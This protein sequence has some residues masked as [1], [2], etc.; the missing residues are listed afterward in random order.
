VIRTWWPRS[1]SARSPRAR[2]YRACALGAAPAL[3]V[4][5]WFALE[6]KPNVL[7]HQALSNF[8]EIQ[9]RTLLHGHWDAS[10][11]AYLFERFNV[12]GRFYT[13]FG[14]WPALLR[15][16]VVLF[17]NRLDGDLSRVSMIL[18]FAVTLVFTARISWQARR[19]I[20][21]EGPPTRAALVAA[22]GFVFVAGC[23]STALFLASATWVYHEAILWGLAWA[24]ASLSYLV[25]Y[26]VAPRRW[27][28][29]LASATA[30][31]SYLS[32]GS[33][34]LG[35]VAGLAIL[36][37]AGVATS[38]R[39]AYRRRA[40]VGV[41]SRPWWLRA[42]GLP[43][44]RDHRS[45][46]SLAVA[47][48]VPLALYAYVNY[49]K[50]GTLFG[51]PPYAQQDLLQ[52]TRRQAALAA[53]E[54]S[55]FGIE[56][57]PTILL[58][59]LR[60]DAIGFDRFFPWVSFSGPPRVVG[61]VVFESM[62]F[63]TSVPS[64][65]TLLVLLAVVGLVVVV[66]APHA[67]GAR[68]TAAALRV[69]VAAAVVASVGTF[70]LAFLEERYQGDFVPLLVLAGAA[71]LW[72]IPRL[73]AAWGRAAR[74]AL[75]IGLVVLAGWTCWATGALTLLQQRAYGPLV[76]TDTRA[77]LIDFQVRVYER[78]PG[79]SPSGVQHGQLPLPAPAAANTLLIVGDCAGLYWSSG[80]FWH[81]VEQTPSTGR[82]HLAIRLDPAPGGTLEPL[83]SATDPRGSSL[84]W[85]RRLG[86]DRV[87]FEYQ[88]TGRNQTLIEGV[89]PDAAELG[90]RISAPVRV[91]P[92]TALTAVIR[93]DPAGYVGIRIGDRQFMSTF[94]PVADARAATGTQAVSARGT[95][96]LAGTIRS[97]ATPTPLCHRLLDLERRG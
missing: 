85:V 4:F 17:T 57:A 43:P 74:A 63:S 14:P 73:S 47:T 61:D 56:Y 23:G 84:L 90:Q 93:L 91:K 2:F 54:G 32:R 36:L 12:D 86:G 82:F 45:I 55:V 71:G 5:A 42:L 30:T 25:E 81:P 35:P 33:V 11:G 8:Y 46:G 18:A 59:Y 15:I 77:R 96:G 50:F 9:A 97:L 88:W 75:V 34:G 19:L 29:V 51:T 10:S 40:P 68:P 31:F 95:P 28:L 92:G 69:P 22:G 79:G 52:G 38:L 6:G 48:A 53:N 27:T 66:R 49:V 67:E 24:V 21:G 13:Y 83:L 3:V 80:R 62:N 87:R 44:D 89:T 39:A 70:V 78:L 16:P 58:Q 65:S 7:A 37:V 1:G 64:T 26:I 76:S 41:G 94:A 72:S 20:R 60:P